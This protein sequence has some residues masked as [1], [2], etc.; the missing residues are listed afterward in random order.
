[1]AHEAT[2]PFGVRVGNWTALAVGTEFAVRRLDEATTDITVTE[3]VVQ[4]LPPNR[5]GSD[6]E[7]RLNANHKATLGA[8]GTI[9]VSQISTTEMGAQLAW[10][11]HLVVFSGVPVR[12]ALAEMNRYSR[13][14]IV[15]N[16]PE[17]LQ[18]RIV[19]VFSTVDSQT[20]ISALQ[21]TLGVEAVESGNTVLLRNV[22]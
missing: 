16:D 18:R 14:R 9:E 21:A 6:A 19:G 2:R 15:V 8:G 11:T 4:M 12:E 17:I 22:N 3:G 20:F 7:P 10:R 13:K 5:S 1:V